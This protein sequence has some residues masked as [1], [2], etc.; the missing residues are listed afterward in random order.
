MGPTGLVKRAEPMF[1]IYTNRGYVCQLDRDGS[2]LKS[3]EAASRY[4]KRF[5][6]REDAQAF[7]ARIQA[8][9]SNRRHYEQNR[10]SVVAA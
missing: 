5:A 8:A 2:I 6:S 1:I 9:Q 10:L 3:Y 7:V 4:V